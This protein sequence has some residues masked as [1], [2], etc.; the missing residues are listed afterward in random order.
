MFVDQ[1]PSVEEVVPRRFDPRPTGQTTR[2]EGVEVIPQVVDDVFREFLRESS[3]EG[4]N[5]LFLLRGF[6]PNAIVE[7][8]FQPGEKRGFLKI[9]LCALFVK[10]CLPER[11]VSRGPTS[12]TRTARG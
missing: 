6:R 7:R 3:C 1:P 9:G 4:L 2:E 5:G 12:I 11:R 8:G 10:S